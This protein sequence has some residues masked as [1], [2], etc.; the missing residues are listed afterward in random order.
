MTAVPLLLGEHWQAAALPMSILC[1]A[2][3]FR[4]YSASSSPVLVA[5]GR[6][7]V[8]FFNLARLC[9]L[10]IVAILVGAN[11]GLLGVSIGWALAVMTGSILA[12]RATLKTLGINWRDC[13]ERIWGAFCAAAV[14]ALAVRMLVEPSQ[15]LESRVLQL[16][17]Q[18]LIGMAVY[19]ALLTVFDRK[20]RDEILSLA[21]RVVK[22]SS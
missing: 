20:G 5:V 21:K 17:V 6:S 13:F 1:L 11:W 3:P 8:S 14:M 15:V 22:P 9:L 18:V 2:I 10:M 4:M 12:F 19:W 16:T 7:D